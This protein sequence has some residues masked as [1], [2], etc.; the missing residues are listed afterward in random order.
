M[1]SSGFNRG[2]EQK[3][4]TF[5]STPSFATFYNK[6]NSL[7]CHE[8]PTKI[9][10]SQAKMRLLKDATIPNVFVFVSPRLSYLLFGGCYTSLLSRPKFSRDMPRFFINACLPSCFW[11]F[12]CSFHMSFKSLISLKSSCSLWHLDNFIF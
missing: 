3:M 6:S 4:E 2:S 8:R 5:V 12:N 9:P 10:I 7:N 1:S 11:I